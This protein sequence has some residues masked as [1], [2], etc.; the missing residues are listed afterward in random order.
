MGKKNILENKKSCKDEFPWF[1][2]CSGCTKKNSACLRSY[3]VC[4]KLHE[5]FVKNKRKRI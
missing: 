3:L 1:D 4:M 5:G 2:A